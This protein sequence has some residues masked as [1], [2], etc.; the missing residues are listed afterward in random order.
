MRWSSAASIPGSPTG[1]K[2]P[3]IPHMACP[4]LLD[5]RA[6][7]GASMNATCAPARELAVVQLGVAAHH[8][9][10]AE[11]FD[12]APARRGTHASP[13]ARVSRE[14]QDRIGERL[15]VARRH[16]LARL[17]RSDQLGIPPH[18]GGNCRNAASHRLE[19]RVRYAFSA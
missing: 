2:I 8:L 11:A 7:A 13:K 6:E 1:L 17:P 10:D 5:R 3:V 12:G 4:F 15:H 16:E 14:A 18:G 19:Q 9:R